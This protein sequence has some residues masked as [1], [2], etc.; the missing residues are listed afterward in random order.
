MADKLFPFLTFIPTIKKAMLRINWDSKTTIKNVKT[1]ILFITGTEDTFVPPEMIQDLYAC[2]KG[3]RELMVVQGGGHNDT[4]MKAGDS[5]GET[6]KKFMKAV[7]AM[8]AGN[9]RQLPCTP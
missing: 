7:V 4:Y 3:Y 9:G 5:Y 8:K 6:M 1:P 2:H